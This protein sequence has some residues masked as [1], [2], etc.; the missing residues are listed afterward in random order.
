MFVYLLIALA[1]FAA[2]ALGNAN[3][4]PNVACDDMIPQHGV[5]PQSSIA[6]YK[7][8][9]SKNEGKSSDVIVVT[10]QG[11][12][13]SD[14]IKG[15]LLQGRVGK[16]PTGSFA[17]EG[18]SHFLNCGSADVSII[19]TIYILILNKLTMKLFQSTVTHTP[20]TDKPNS[21]SFSWIA[22]LNFSGKV[23]FRFVT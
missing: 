23:V 15:F 4:A 10:I 8:I 6:P 3:G 2:P 9:V 21:L 16:T 7:I 5:N 18:H 20:F 11:N 14:T 12:T 13:A 17:P 1:A 22:P 19:L